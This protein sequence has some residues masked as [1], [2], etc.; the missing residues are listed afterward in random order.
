MTKMIVTKKLLA[1]CLSIAGLLAA[2]VST[3]PTV[4]GQSERSLAGRWL[5]TS[6]PINGEIISR[7]GNSLGFPDREMFFERDGDLRLG[8]VDRGELGPDVKPLGVWR[9]EGDRFSAT[10][11]LWCPEEDRA[12][13][14]IIM[15]G[16]FLDDSTIRGTM[17]VFWDEEDPTR[18]TGFDTW[19]M[20]FRGS[21]R[22]Q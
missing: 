1:L 18:P 7:Q 8:Q 21:R 3:S 10:F 11:Q 12:C 5:V 16:R 15:R 22:A 9:V 2:S 20:S 14:S 4:Q 6:S 17:T 19:T 13:G